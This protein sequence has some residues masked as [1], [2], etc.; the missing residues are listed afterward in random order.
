[1][2]NWMEIIGCVFGGSLIAGIGSIL[3]FR[4]RLSEAKST[5]SKAETEADKARYDYLVERIESTEKLFALQG[6]ELNDVREKLIAMG[7]ELTLKERKIAQLEV[8]NKAL[9]D[10]VAILEK[11]LNERKVP[12]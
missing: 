12:K 11:R 6:E 8:E 4:P 5:A 2:I 1:M 10:K 7:K 3:Y 9:S